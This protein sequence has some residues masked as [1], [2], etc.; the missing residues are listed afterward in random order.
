[1]KR[2]LISIILIASLLGCVGNPWE[3][4]LGNIQSFVG[5]DF[6]A[7]KDDLEQHGSNE[8]TTGGGYVLPNGNLQHEFCW[9]RCENYKKCIL[10]IEEDAYSGEVLVVG[11]KGDTRACQWGG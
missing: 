7:V 6:Q 1:M 2:I 10:L 11:G 3:Q 4:F 8:L 5:K 9:A